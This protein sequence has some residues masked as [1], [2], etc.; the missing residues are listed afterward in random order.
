MRRGPIQADL[1]KA[2]L[3]ELAEQ[4][5]PNYGGFGSSSKKVAE[6]PRTRN[7]DVPLGS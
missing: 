6:V 5:D 2:T 7:F 1:A 4:F 3:V